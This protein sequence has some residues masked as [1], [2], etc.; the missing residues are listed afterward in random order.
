MILS[1][2]KPMPNLKITGQPLPGVYLL[3]CPA[4]VD[5]RGAFT[6]VFHQKSFDDQEI[7]LNVAESF[8][9]RSKMN[10]LRGMHFQTGKAAH[11]KLVTCIKGSVLDVVVCINPRSR[12]FNQPF[13]TI[14]SENESNSI[15][16]A[17]DYAHG[18]L[19]LDNDS[20]M[21]YYT[22][23]LHDPSRDEGVLW[24]SIAYDWPV[25]NPVISE[26]D[27]MFKAIGK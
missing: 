13:S 9:T 22:S 4:I 1:Q 10:V 25:K 20:W 15:L 14:L 17:P 27:S 21:M 8:L 19:S 12:Y 26:R 5:N 18:F 6:K 7:S 23:T 2:A 24:N 3:N 11:K 16:I